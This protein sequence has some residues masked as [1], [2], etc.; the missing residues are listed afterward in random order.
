[1]KKSIA[2]IASTL[3]TTML[4]AEQIKRIDFV[5]LSR[6][7]PKIA[8]ETIDFK[9]GDEIDIPKINQA[10]KKFYKFGYFADISVQNENGILQFIFKELPVIANIDVTGYKERKDDLNLLYSRIGIKKGTHFTDRKIKNAKKSLLVELEKEGYVN[11]VVEVSIEHINEN[12]IALTFDVNKGE[13]I[14]IK[15]VNY[16]GSENLDEEDFESVTANKKESYFPWFYGQNDGEV[17]LDQLKIEQPRIKDLYYQHGY[18]DATIA[19]P[20]MKVDFTSN[21]AELNFFI[22]E[23]GQYNTN[24]VKI[25]LDSTIYDPKKLYPNLKLKKNQKFNIQLLRKDINFIKTTISD[26]G[27][28]FAKVEYNLTKN[29]EKSLV[30]VTYNVIPGEKVYIN[31]VIISGNHRTLDRVIRRNVYLAPGDLYNLTDFTDSRNKLKRSGFFDTVEIEKKRISSSQM[32]LI[33]KVK[34]TSTGNIILGGGYGSYDGFLLTAGIKDSNVFGSGKSVSAKVDYSKHKQDISLSLKEPSINDSK[35][36]GSVSIYNKTKEIEYN[37]PDYTF[38][39]KSMGISLGVGTELMRNTFTGL[40]YKLESIKETY[41]DDIATDSYDPFA[42]KNN[43]D[44]ILSSIKPYVSFNDTDDHMFPRNGTKAQTSLEFAGLGGDAKFMKSLSSYKY[45]YSLEDNFEVDWIIRYKSTLQFLVDNGKIT[46]GDSFYL[47]GTSSLRGFES[48]AFGPDND[49]N[50]PALKQMFANSIELSFPLYSEKLRWNLFYD[51]GMIGEDKMTDIKRSSTG[52]ALE[53]V[54]PIGPVQLIFAKPIG[55]KS[56]D[57]TTSFE[58]TL[59]Q[60]F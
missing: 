60:S 25:Y 7:S 49:S 45:F 18:L 9:V 40:V 48:F 37:S 11:S 10:I 12:S 57:K 27:Y 51:Y 22:Q 8:N 54:S 16:F 3:I 43:D 50:D 46:Q 19:K 44:Y 36:N 32:N 24:D 15:K 58:F 14:I 29:K 38:K 47:G 17:K 2:F 5:N 55:D 20:F 34:E 35:Y 39:K 4:S 53:W 41:T 23:G 6:M 26:L 33:V 13:E 30:D 1:M 42:Y 59:G 28:A 56:G 31:D 21:N 52:A